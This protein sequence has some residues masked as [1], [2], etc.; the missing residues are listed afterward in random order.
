MLKGREIVRK[1]AH[2]L[3][4]WGTLIG[5]CLS[6]IWNWACKNQPTWEIHSI[7]ELKGVVERWCQQHTGTAWGELDI[8]EML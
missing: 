3:K 5:R 2:L 4:Q 6:V 1:S 7:S 8:E